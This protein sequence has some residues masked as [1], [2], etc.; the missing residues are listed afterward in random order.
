M[1][2]TDKPGAGPEMKNPK[3]MI[4]LVITAPIV[5]Y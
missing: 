3:P 4:T 2:A 1:R 5:P